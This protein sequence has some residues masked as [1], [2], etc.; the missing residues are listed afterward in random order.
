MR[1]TTIFALGLALGAV[2][3][4]DDTSSKG[5]GMDM[6]ASEFPTAP[7]I[8]TTQLDRMGRAGINTALTDPFYTDKTAHGV[9]QDAYNQ[10]PESMWPT[11]TDQFA[12]ALGVLDGL[13]GICGNQPLADKSGADASAKGEYGAL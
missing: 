8:G 3:C 1:L 4:D 7:T 10:A 11:F 12:A 9:K 13:D 2:G 5:G 6:A